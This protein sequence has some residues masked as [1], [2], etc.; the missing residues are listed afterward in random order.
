MPAISQRRLVNKLLELLAGTLLLG[1]DLFV[2]TIETRAQENL[3]TIRLCE[4]LRSPKNFSQTQER[5]RRHLRLAV[6]ANRTLRRT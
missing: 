3:K 5:H 4:K 2:L 1:S 6:P